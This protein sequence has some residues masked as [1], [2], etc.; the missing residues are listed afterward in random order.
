MRQRVAGDLAFM[1]DLC[2]RQVAASL[3]P[4]GAFVTAVVAM[5]VNDLVLLVTWWVLLQR[6]EHVRGWRLPD[7]LCLYA[8]ATGGV[9][10]CL[11]LCGGLQD[12]S[13][14]IQ[15]GELDARL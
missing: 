4:R 5:F 7:M 8:V 14:K 15:D 12:L 1:F 11:I 9:G 3:V 13:R 6:F 2:R 10:L